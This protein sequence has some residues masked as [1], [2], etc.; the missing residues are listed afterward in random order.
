MAM[1]LVLG[2]ESGA[3][4]LHIVVNGKDCFYGAAGSVPRSVSRQHCKLIVDDS[5]NYTIVN[6]KPE[7]VT[8]VNGLPVASKRFQPKTD[9]VELGADRYQLAVPV[10]LKAL[11]GDKEPPKTYSIAHLEKVWDEYH[12]TKL[13]MQI[14]EKKTAAIRSVTGVFSM[15]A[16]ACGF[17]PGIAELTALRVL[18]YAVGLLLAVYFFVKLYRSSSEQPKF[19]DALD[20]KFRR[21]YVCPN[22]DC[23]QFMGYQPY[24]ELRRKTTCPCC[25]SKLTDK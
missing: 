21:N 19:M 18:L 24:E 12:D 9:Q 15:A 22:P 25:R 20:K 8:Y 14:K 16:V 7:N 17:I 1:E 23:K 4:R 6:L 5:G 10:I 11:L 2:R 3:S 13:D